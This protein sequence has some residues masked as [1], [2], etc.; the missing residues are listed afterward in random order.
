MAIPDYQSLMLPVLELTADGAEHRFRDAIDALAERL[1][2][3]AEER[4]TLLPSGTQPIFANRVGWAKTYLKK[5]GLIASPRRG[6]FRITDAGRA[7]LATQPER[8]DNRLLRQYPSFQAF[9]QQKNEQTP[10]EPPAAPTDET[11]DDLMARAYRELRADLE[12]R[13][14]DHVKEQSATFFEHLAIDLLVQMGYGGNRE[15][16]ARA[17]GRNNDEGIDGV[18]DEDKLGL[19]VVYVQAK[20]WGGTVGRPTIQQ[21]VGALQGKRARKGI[22]LTTSQ[23]SKG[24]IDYAANVDARIVLIDGPRLARLMVDHNV[25][26][27]T[28]GT[29]AVKKID[30]DYFIDD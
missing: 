13:L 15:D 25:G 5:A 1:S 18:I 7:L 24:A 2:L 22:V 12:A 27:S 14:L 23:F 6:Y 10:T 16:A 21:F 3:S 28:V 30:T 8:I 4:R 17:I 26:V 29:Y 11:P 9:Q 19:D 20:R